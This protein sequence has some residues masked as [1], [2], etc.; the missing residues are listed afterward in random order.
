M[1]LNVEFQLINQRRSICKST[2][3]TYS[4]FY[5]TS[6]VLTHDQLLVEPWLSRVGAT[7]GTTV[8]SDPSHNGSLK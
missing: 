7:V 1:L 8:Q 2:L 5:I 3:S 4:S 6:S